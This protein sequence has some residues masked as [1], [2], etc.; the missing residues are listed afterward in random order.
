[1]NIAWKHCV[2]DGTVYECLVSE[3]YGT[4]D[5]AWGTVLSEYPR[6]GPLP[7]CTV[8]RG[9][10][11]NTVLGIR[12]AKLA[13]VVFST[14]TTHGSSPF[15]DLMEVVGMKVVVIDEN[16]TECPPELVALLKGG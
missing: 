3:V 13:V 14:D 4:T 6:K 2:P 16:T 7:A 10:A 12:A 9:F 1:M 8:A 15:E 11:P 5:V